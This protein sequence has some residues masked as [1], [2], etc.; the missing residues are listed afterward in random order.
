MNKILQIEIGEFKERESVMF[1]M[2][3]EASIIK[4]KERESIKVKMINQNKS[5]IVEKDPSPMKESAIGE[6]N[7]L[8][9]KSRTT[10]I[11]EDEFDEEIPIDQRENLRSEAHLKGSKNRIYFENLV[12]KNI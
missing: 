3:K 10:R 8:S 5:I 2:V 4:E 7:I 9:K 6:I 12:F 11:E 1:S